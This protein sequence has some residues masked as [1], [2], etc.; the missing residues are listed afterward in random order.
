MAGYEVYKNGENIY[1]EGKP[2]DTF[3]II[4]KGKVRVYKTID[5]KETE[6]DKLG[7]GDIIDELSFFLNKK[8]PT[9]VDALEETVVQTFSEESF[10]S[11]LMTE[12]QFATFLLRKLSKRIVDLHSQVVRLKSAA[13]E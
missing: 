6:L 3:L 13:K 2:A 11:Y 9:S 4:R 7:A 1:Q 5:D 12:P 10:I 8:R